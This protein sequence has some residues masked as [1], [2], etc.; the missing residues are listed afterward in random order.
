MDYILLN[1]F[2]FWLNVCLQFVFLQVDMCPCVMLSLELFI[3]FSFKGWQKLGS[4]SY[5]KE[6]HALVFNSHC[7]CFFVR[8][9]NCILLIRLLFITMQEGGP[10][11]Q[12]I[13]EISHMSKCTLLDNLADRVCFEMS[14]QEPGGVW[15]LLHI[16]A[17][18]TAA[19]YLWVMP[20][21]RTIKT[22]FWNKS[23]T[24]TEAGSESKGQ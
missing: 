22:S 4:S 21:R 12:L 13:R 8:A 2:T 20:C 9:S 1:R 16:I 3:I 14:S 17:T 10:V 11:F 7:L 24:I 23:I 5:I 6:R 18:G 15:L 19:H